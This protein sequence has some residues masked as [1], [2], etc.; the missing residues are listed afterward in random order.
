MAT[1]VYEA[2]LIRWEKEHEEQI[3]WELE[4]TYQD[5]NGNLVTLDGCK[6]TPMPC[7]WPPQRYLKS[8]P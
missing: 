2:E 4:N 7:P 3:K 6:A 8:A 5:E 1:D